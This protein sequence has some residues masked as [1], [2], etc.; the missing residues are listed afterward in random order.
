MIT[1]TVKVNAPKNGRGFTITLNIASVLDMIH[2]QSTDRRDVL[3]LDALIVKAQAVARK[4]LEDGKSDEVAKRAFLAYRYGGAGGNGIS[5]MTLEDAKEQ[6]F[7]DS[8]IAWLKAQG[9]II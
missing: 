1:K 2:E 5:P 8:N 3:A 6:K 7:S 9:M 4:L